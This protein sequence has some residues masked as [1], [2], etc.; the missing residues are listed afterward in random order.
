M[1]NDVQVYALS[2]CIHCKKAKQYLD[3]CKVPYE[4]IHVD[5]LSGE[6]RKA[7]IE[8]VK[9]LNPSLSFPTIC[10]NGKVVVGFNQTEIDKA[11]G[12]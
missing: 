10:I 11:L 2:T 4:T 8:A 6:E 7:A 1:S 5:L 3:E 12:K 9:K